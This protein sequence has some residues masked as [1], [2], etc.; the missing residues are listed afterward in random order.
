ME[1]LPDLIRCNNTR[2]IMKIVLLNGPCLGKFARTGRWQAVSRGASLWY[3]IWLAACASALEDAGFE[4][5]LIDAPA[6]DYSLEQTVSLIKELSPDLCVIDTSTASINYDFQTAREIKRTMGEGVK[7]CFVGPH[8]SALPESVL[9]NE[10]VDYAAVSEYDYTVRELAVRLKKD[11]E[12]DMRDVCGLWSKSAGNIIRNPERPLIMNLDELP[13]AS[14]SLY[15]DLDIARYGLDFTLHP[16]MNIMT[17]R[18]CP[19]KCSYCLWPQTLSRG[20]YRE[21]S[22]DHVFAEIDFVLGARPRVREIF[23]D[24]DTFTVRPERVKEFCRRYISRGYKIPF[25]VNARADINDYDML[26][27]MKKAGLRCL[28]VGFESG[29]Q[30]IL[31][32]VGKNTRLQEMSGFARLC[33]KLKIQVHGDFVV[34]L[35]GETAQ[36]IANTVRFA[37]TLSLSTFQLS[38]AMPLPGTEFYRWLKDNRYLTTSDFA[39]WLDKNGL[40]KCV[41]NYPQLSS[42]DIERSVV[43]SLK[44]Y[45]FSSQFFMNAAGQILNNPHELKRYVS[46]GVRF[47]QFLFRSR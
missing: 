42:G 19:A 11:K 25:S 28:V 45:Y 3:P 40:Q 23:F 27:L 31:D 32:R 15:K 34:G 12:D 26:A 5:R 14:R 6:A 10:F 17:S 41:I 38:I 18:G 7:I 8:A 24:D 29:N 37:R 36:T 33:R 47:A 20:K 43:K 21:R 9:H 46:G 1:R 2:G 13:F 35:P 22:L 44:E 30:E 16:Y 39:Q 4:T